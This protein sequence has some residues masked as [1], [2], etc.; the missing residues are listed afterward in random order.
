MHAE[1]EEAWANA[2]ALL[3]FVGMMGTQRRVVDHTSLVQPWLPVK[4]SIGMLVPETLPRSYSGG[5]WPGSRTFK[6]FLGV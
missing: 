2:V 1:G 3:L 6:A 5:R 4:T